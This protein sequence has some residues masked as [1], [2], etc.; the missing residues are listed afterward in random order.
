MPSSLEAD[1]V[2]DYFFSAW[3]VILMRI[4]D[5]VTRGESLYFSCSRRIDTYIVRS[6]LLSSWCSTQSGGYHAQSNSAFG[7]SPYSCLFCKL[8][9]LALAKFCVQKISLR[10]WYCGRRKG[11]WKYAF[12]VRP[13][14]YNASSESLESMT[15][16]TLQQPWPSP[17]WT[18]RD[19]MKNG[20]VR[21]EFGGYLVD[22]W[23]KTEINLQLWILASCL[24]TEH[25]AFQHNALTFV[26]YEVVITGFDDLVLY[27]ERDALSASIASLLVRREVFDL[28]CFCTLWCPSSSI[29][30]DLDITLRSGLLV[31]IAYLLCLV[32]LHRMVIWWFHRNTS[33]WFY[34]K[35]FWCWAEL[36][37]LDHVSRR[38][39]FVLAE[40][41]VIGEQTWGFRKFGKPEEHCTEHL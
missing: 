9:T 36:S 30:A 14:Q 16:L 23:F 21:P 6:F 34:W 27:W 32:I 28:Q 17:L 7:H 25:C 12:W 35:L 22:L 13:P 31:S 20:T 38:W 26:F 24:S 5:R 2:R 8:C 10:D 11:V 1:E 39:N 19:F 41:D 29:G 15:L 33:H 18:S 4:S 40:R 3:R 37:A